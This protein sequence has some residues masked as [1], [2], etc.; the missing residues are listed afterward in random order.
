MAYVRNMMRLYLCFFHLRVL[1]QLKRGICIFTWFCL[2]L[3]SA[4]RES[5]WVSQLG[6]W[7]DKA[8][9]RQQSGE[10][11]QSNQSVQRPEM[12]KLEPIPSNIIPF[13][14]VPPD[15]I[16]S[17]KVPSS[18]LH[19][20]PNFK[21][22]PTDPI[23]QST[24]LLNWNPSHPTVNRYHPIYYCLIKYHPIIWSVQQF[25]SNPRHSIST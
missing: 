4:K 19:P 18:I 16:P 3:D 13:L 6:K 12:L 2:F 10:A 15:S 7:V 25:P 17:D 14:I 24:D 9:V 11:N 8:A 22:N 1:M 23:S 21:I 20:N 5:R